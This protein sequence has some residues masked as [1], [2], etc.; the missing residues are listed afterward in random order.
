MK[1]WHRPTWVCL[2]TFA[3][4]AVLGARRIA[5]GLTHPV[6]MGIY[7]GAIRDLEDSSF[8]RLSY[9]FQR[10]TSSE[11]FC[12]PCQRALGGRSVARTRQNEGVV[13]FYRGR[14]SSVNSAVFTH[15]ALRQ[16]VWAHSSGTASPTIRSARMDKALLSMGWFNVI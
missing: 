1:S 10:L 4:G 7:S 6:L 16:R 9:H 12:A 11:R 2:L 13:R 3:G 14:N 5:G 8:L 15:V